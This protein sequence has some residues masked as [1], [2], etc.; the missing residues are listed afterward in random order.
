MRVS[1][2]AGAEGPTVCAD[3]TSGASTG[4]CVGGARRDMVEAKLKSAWCPLCLFALSLS[5]AFS[6]IL[7]HRSFSVRALFGE[8]FGTYGEW[9]NHSFAAAYPIRQ[10]CFENRNHKATLRLV[11]LDVSQ[12]FCGQTG[13]HERFGQSRRSHHAI[14]KRG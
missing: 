14:A 13:C 12:R 3:A 2:R 9:S 8:A 6:C 11:G 5:F 4:A 7:L 10:R 1:R